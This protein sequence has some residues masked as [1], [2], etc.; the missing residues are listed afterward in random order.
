MGNLRPKGANPLL[1]LMDAQ[2]FSFFFRGSER[3]Y[4]IVSSSRCFKMDLMG[5]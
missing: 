4:C 5:T 3:K 2:S 1:S